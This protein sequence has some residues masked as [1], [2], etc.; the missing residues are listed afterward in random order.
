MATARR[1][2][3][4]K[5]KLAAANAFIAEVQKGVERL[6]GRK[7]R[8]GR[9]GD[10]PSGNEYEIDTRFGLL[11]VLPYDTWVHTKFEEPDRAKAALM[12][13]NPYSGKW[14]H[15]Y[16]TLAGKA[17]ADSFLRQLA[18]VVSRANPVGATLAATKAEAR[19]LASRGNAEGWKVVVGRVLQPDGDASYA[20]RFQPE[21]KRE[22][23]GAGLWFEPITPYTSAKPN[24]TSRA[25]L[26]RQVK[27]D[28]L[29]RNVARG[30]IYFAE[31]YAGRPLSVG[32]YKAAGKR[33]R[34]AVFIGNTPVEVGSASD[35]VAHFIA[36]A[37]PDSVRASGT[38]A[39]RFQSNPT[40]GCSHKDNPLGWRKPV[41]PAP[42]AAHV[43]WEAVAKIVNTRLSEVEPPGRVHNTAQD[44]Y[45]SPSKRALKWFKRYEYP[46]GSAYKISR[47]EARRLLDHVGVKLDK[48]VEEAINESFGEYALNPTKRDRR[49]RL[50]ERT[51]I[52]E[53]E[54]PA[55]ISV[56]I[57]DTRDGEIENA[58]FA[59]DMLAA[60]HAVESWE[61]ENRREGTQRWLVLIDGVPAEMVFS[62][63][64]RPIPGGR[65]AMATG[66][67][68]GPYA[69]NP[70]REVPERVER[71]FQE[72]MEQG[73]N[74]EPQAWAI[75]WS[76][77][78][79]YAEPESGHCKLRRSEYFP[80]RGGKGSKG[81]H[82]G[83]AT[84]LEMALVDGHI[85]PD[86]KVLTPS[87]AGTDLYKRAMATLKKWAMRMTFDQV[88]RVD[89]EVE[90]EGG[91]TYEGQIDLSREWVSKDNIAAHIKRHLTLMAGRGAPARMTSQQYANYLD[92]L[93]PDH[94]VRQYAA[95]LLDNCDIGPSRPRLPTKLPTASQKERST[96]RRKSPKKPSAPKKRTSA[97]RKTKTPSRP[98][99]KRASGDVLKGGYADKGAPIGVDAGE[100]AAGI[101]VEMEHTSDPKIARE[102]AYDH[103]T[104]DPKYYTKLATIEDESR[105]N[106]ERA[107]Q[108]FL[109]DAQ[110]QAKGT[111]DIGIERGR[112]YVR[113]FKTDKQG[114]RSAYGFVDRLTGDVLKAASWKSP[115]KGPRGNIY[116]GDYRVSA[117]SVQ[118]GPAAPTS[119]APKGRA[120]KYV[121]VDTR[122]GSAMEGIALTREEAEADVYNKLNEREADK[123]R[124]RMQWPV[125]ERAM[126]VAP[127]R[128]RSPKKA[129][130][131][132]AS[133]KASPKKR[134]PK[135]ASPKA[136]SPKKATSPWERLA[137][138]AIGQTIE[139]DT[140]RAHRYAGSLSLA[141]LRNAG[142]R[143]KTSVSFMVDQPSVPLARK[144]LRAAEQGVTLAEMRKLVPEGTGERERRGVDVRAPGQK[145]VS[146]QGVGIALSSSPQSF[147]V[148]ADDVNQM[149]MMPPMRA[150][151]TAIKKFYAWAKANENK[152][153]SMT[154]SDLS[155]ALGKAGIKYHSYC[156]MD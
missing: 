19:R 110:N 82:K 96:A 31:N 76:R 149:R 118:G 33:S 143:G 70:T 155:K 112:R 22:K 154:W 72:A 153:Q 132:K 12:Y 148:Q 109:H 128:K 79:K 88:W 74:T 51:L 84:R 75:A 60:S 15:H 139:N 10:M 105:A 44:I 134:S 121:I 56:A 24:P 49:S 27:T 133:K 125:D 141:D 7:V 41:R 97:P 113:V 138:N 45:A 131:K 48:M 18:S 35:A 61:D 17:E 92:H 43:D 63:P 137:M 151:K 68:R 117:R 102:I 89:F 144:L 55:P 46:K 99:L 126:L 30:G 62:G 124:F 101:E 115:A 156:G 73:G 8:A 26:R 103:L 116:S 91:Q 66:R 71:Y 47:T 39:E 81:A 23:L 5:Q 106:F 42:G 111:Y 16:P 140:W 130:P 34:F 95:D 119:K 94:A 28:S 53:P 100:I 83:A 135:K 80:G 108:R 4:K 127:L 142:K 57:I 123:T 13:V 78:C 58:Y 3:T 122:D 107:L 85:G 59:P 145:T 86:R 150:S 87:S 114:G 69:S 90:F 54:R 120:V 32:P 40:C 29:K 50:F 104:E 1:K 147:S 77:Y 11:R 129:S 21:P 152:I 65:Y 38:T 25:Q 6:G 36:L 52:D 37:K 98:R 67:A 14:N 20:I 146:V 64:A 9:S 136:C 93:D 2:P